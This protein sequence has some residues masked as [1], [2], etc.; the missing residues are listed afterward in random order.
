MQVNS[1]NI[2]RVFSHGGNILYLL[3][4]FQREYTWDKDNWK[5]LLADIYNIC[6]PDAVDQKAEHFLGSLV[7]INDGT[8]DGIITAL[9]LVDGQQRLITISLILSALYHLTEKNNQQLALNI[10]SLLVN[11]YASGPT[12]FKIRPTKKYDDRAVYQAIITAETLPSST[13]SKIP[14]AYNYIY[15]ELDY[16]LSKKELDPSQLFLALTNRLYVVVIDLD[17]KERPYE[18]FE[19][20]NTKGKPLTQ[21]DMVRNYIAMRLP[22]DKQEAIFDQSWS[23]DRRPTQ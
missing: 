21:P 18:I 2:S 11:Q 12:Q 7:I 3:P 9:K 17:S 23:K 16:K 5:T 20:L 4:H 1:F 19:S 14:A 13:R 10:K 15:K 22:E 8:R 6:D